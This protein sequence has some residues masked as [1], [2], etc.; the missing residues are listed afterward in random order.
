[1]PLIGIGS[2]SGS[3]DQSETRTN[4]IYGGYN[5]GPK[6]PPGGRIGAFGPMCSDSESGGAK[7]RYPKCKTGISRIGSRSH[8]N[9]RIFPWA[10]FS[11]TG[12]GVTAIA[13]R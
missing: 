6:A 9:F 1:M 8:E 7:V 3:I 10:Y 13:I 11:R 4:P 5:L 12:S 2:A